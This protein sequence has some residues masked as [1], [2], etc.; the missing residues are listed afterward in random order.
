M[1]AEATSGGGEPG[2]GFPPGRGT[3]VASRICCRVGGADPVEP[4]F[5]VVGEHADVLDGRSALSAPP[6]AARADR[7]AR[8]SGAGR[9]GQSSAAIRY[10]GT[11][12]AR[13]RPPGSDRCC[14]LGGVIHGKI[15]RGRYSAVLVIT[16]ATDRRGARR[17]DGEFVKENTSGRVTSA[18]VGIRS[19]TPCR[20]PGVLIRLPIVLDLRDEVLLCGA[21]DFARILDEAE[22][23]NQPAERLVGIWSDRSSC[24]FPDELVPDGLRDISDLD[25]SMHSMHN[26]CM[27]GRPQPPRPSHA[28]RC[29]LH[30]HLPQ[31]HCRQGGAVSG[32][33]RPAGRKRQGS[34]DASSGSGASSRVPSWPRRSTLPLIP[35]TTS[36]SPC[37]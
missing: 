9:R 2:F 24:G 11:E 8:V 25:Q 4:A 27:S 3:A 37:P 19:W 16:T 35:A 33:A 6:A 10:L 34:P 28:G 29:R 5:T 12:A 23:D 32:P 22:R 20:A 1:Y 18:T 31:R 26:P 30:A 7:P 15:G 17:I 13:V 14:R 36:P 21:Y